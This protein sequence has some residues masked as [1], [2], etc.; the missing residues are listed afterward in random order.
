MPTCLRPSRAAALLAVGAAIAA[1][2]AG[3]LAADAPISTL[4]GTTSGVAGDGGPATQAQL[5]GPQGVALAPDGRILIADSVNQ[6]VRQVA[7]DGNISTI[8]I[9]QPPPTTFVPPPGLSGTPGGVA[10]DLAGQPLVVDTTGGFV[11]RI[12]SN[13][14]VT[15][16]A[17]TRNVGGF[18]GDGGAATSARF[19]AP[20]G[21]AV[22]P[23]GTIYVADTGNSRI[24]RIGTNGVISTVA[25]G[26]VAGFAGDGGQA[27]S[28]SL[29]APQGVAVALDGGLLIADTANN[30][31]R[32]VDPQGVIT[33]AA[34]SSAAAF[35]GDGA[36]ATDAALSSPV[37]VAPLRLG[38]FVVADT[39][40]D[41]LRRVTPLGTIFTIAGGAGGLAGDGGPASASRLTAPRAIVPNASGGFVVADTGNSRIRGLASDGALPGPTPGRS[42][43]LSP[44]GGFSKAFIAGKPASQPIREPDL[45]QLGSKID[46]EKG[47]V[48]VETGTPSGTLRTANVTSG[49]FTIEQPL[50]PVETNFKLSA[51]MNGCRS[52]EGGAGTGSAADKVAGKAAKSRPLASAAAAKKKKPKRKRRTRKIFIESDGGHRSSGRYADAVVRGTQWTI[53]DYCTNTRVTVREGLVEVFDLAKKKSVLVPAGER[54]ISR[55]KK[56]KK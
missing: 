13:G 55:L 15:V 14:A 10:Y 45:V 51:P 25:G 22:A 44:A 52:F 7:A 31:I 23:D 54:Y 37:G 21:I 49:Q 56:P 16:I 42:L 5:S 53:Q 39:G 48:T 2:P 34:G 50:G 36:P 12:G 20:T 6:R 46:T 35:A 18:S 1:F 24:R 28:A 29:N 47:R 19:N 8:A 41:R 3:A 33:T 26:G 11:G 27:R 4:A 9:V 30:R 38:G 32:R 43:R 40:N 17:G